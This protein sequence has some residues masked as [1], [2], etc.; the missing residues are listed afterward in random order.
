MKMEA[1]ISA[2]CQTLGSNLPHGAA[3]LSFLAGI[4]ASRNGAQMTEPALRGQLLA[5]EPMARH[6]SWHAGGAARA[7]D[8]EALIGL[9]QRAVKDKFG[10]ELER[11][12]RIVGEQG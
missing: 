9:A 4:A 10:I 6:V 5:R 3:H 1:V 7:A 2:H 12:V 8:I 11:E